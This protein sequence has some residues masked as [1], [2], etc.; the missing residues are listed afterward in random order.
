MILAPYTPRRP[1]QIS[2]PYYVLS[3]TDLAPAE[4][5][6]RSKMVPP[7]PSS[8]MQRKTRQPLYSDARGTHHEDRQQLLEAQSTQYSF[9]SHRP[10]L[11]PP[12]SDTQL[13][14]TLATGQ[15]GGLSQM[16]APSAGQARSHGA[17]SDPYPQPK[18]PLAAI[19]YEQENRDQGGPHEFYIQ[20]PGAHAET[21]HPQLMAQTTVVGEESLPTPPLILLERYLGLS[22]QRQSSKE[23]SP[24]W[25]SCI[26]TAQY[27]CLALS[28]LATAALCVLILYITREYAVPRTFAPLRSADE[29]LPTVAPV[30]VSQVSSFREAT[31]SSQNDY[32]S[33]IP[34]S[35][36]D[37]DVGDGVEPR[38]SAP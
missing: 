12:T 13:L 24:R 3:L 20:V 1:P 26:R 25:V 28:V 17:D 14:E 10:V 31:N 18:D 32:A 4:Q 38:K 23:M 16:I 9:G 2:S 11:G 37:N 36:M 7:T 6:A 30:S 5:S 15:A 19:L 22:E 27:I 29:S 33:G 8:E 34:L 35:V 21:F